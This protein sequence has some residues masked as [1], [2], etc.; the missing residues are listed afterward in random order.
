MKMISEVL[1]EY[2]K[3][4][5]MSKQ[6]EMRL[7]QSY[8][9]YPENAPFTPE[10]Y[11]NLHWY[12]NSQEQWGC[13]I[14]SEYKGLMIVPGKLSQVKSFPLDSSNSYR[15]PVPLHKADVPNSFRA[16]MAW[17]IDANGWG[18]YVYLSRSW[19][20]SSNQYI[21]RHILITKG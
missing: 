7:N 14:Q 21:V 5:T 13:W 11:E 16:H 12:Y 3:E 18:R 19:D 1:D 6:L 9:G 2:E 8:P 17:F 10:S 15:S 20:S 4:T